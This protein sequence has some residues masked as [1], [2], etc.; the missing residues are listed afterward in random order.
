MAHLDRLADLME[1]GAGL[2]LAE[3]LLVP[4]VGVEVLVDT[5]LLLLR[6]RNDDVGAVLGER[7]QIVH[8]A[9]QRMAIDGAATELL[10]LL[11]L[12]V[13]ALYLVQRLVD[14]L[15]EEL[16]FREDIHALQVRRGQIDEVTI[17]GGRFGRCCG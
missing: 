14:G 5:L 15:A 9:D 8:A 17:R 11:Q 7:H 10:I 3:S 2:R 13:G 16:L 12:E 4:D 6:R 1:D